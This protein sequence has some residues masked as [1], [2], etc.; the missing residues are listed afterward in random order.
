MIEATFEYHNRSREIANTLRYIEKRNMFKTMLRCR[1]DGKHRVIAVFE[2]E[3]D[4]RSVARQLSSVFGLGCLV[5]W[6]NDVMGLI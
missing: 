4:I 2:H 5:T 3:E 1:M 6:N